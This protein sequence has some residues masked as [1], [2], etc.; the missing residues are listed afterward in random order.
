VAA[1]TDEQDEDMNDTKAVASQPIR[2]G[3][4]A[5]DFRA[6]TTLG[7][8]S[9]SEYRGQW[10]ILFSHP[11]DFTPVCTTEFV[12]L[13]KSAAAFEATGCALLGL[14]VDSI[15]SH[16]AWVAAIKHKFGVNVPFPIIEDPSMAIGRAYGMIDDTAVDSAAV[17]STY[18]I[19]PE[20]VIRAITT[21]PH[22][23]GRSVSEMLRLLRA[24]QATQGGGALAPEG[25][26]PGDQLLALPVINSAEIGVNDDWFC[27]LADAK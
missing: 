14:S 27:Q 3:E 7:E 9:L 12:A 24:L 16:I 25:W 11:A 26:Q 5:P 6:R 22:N 1:P 19:D 18:F 17:R 8:R 15:H 23:V 13:A 21:Y 4:T 20:G 2:I 10:L